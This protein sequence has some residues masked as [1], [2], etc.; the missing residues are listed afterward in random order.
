[1]NT[2]MWIALVAVVA[3]TACG[4]EEQGQRIELG[5]QPAQQGG[6]DSWPAELAA[7]VDSANA[8]YSDQDYDAA[9]QRYQALTEAYPEIGTVWFG[10]YMAENARGNEEEAQAALQKAEELAPGLGMMHEA[11]QTMDGEGHPSMGMP[12]GHPPLDSV[13]PE[14]AP[15]L[16]M[17]G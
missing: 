7:Q 13:N 4:G 2:R 15:P 3:M 14:D 10:L 9:A 1:M 17:G 11:A 12:A 8:E 5:D 6:R 16:D